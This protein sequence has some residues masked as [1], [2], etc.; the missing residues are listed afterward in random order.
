MTPG[1]GSATAAA[2]STRPAP[3][4]PLTATPDE[5]ARTGVV[6]GVGAYLL[7]GLLPLFLRLLHA[8]PALQIVAHRVLWSLVLLALVALARG[9]LSGVLAAARAPRALP[10]LCATAA[11]IAVNWSIYVWAAVNGHVVEASL[12]YFINPLVNVLLGVA[13]LGERLRRAQVAAVALAAVG[14]AAMAV[15]QGAALGISLG[16]ALSFG[17]YGLL[18]KLAPVEAFEGLAIESALLAPLALAFLL[19]AGAGGAGAWGRDGA[20]ELLLMLSGPVTAVPLLLFAAA[21]RRMRLATLGLLQYLSPTLQFL[22]GVL[23]FGEHLTRVH[24]FTFGCIWIG[25]I[26]YAADTLRAARATA[27]VPP[28]E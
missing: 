28:P 2:M 8:V 11:L 7:W 4:P 5:R 19:Y 25:L 1:G 26:V 3:L 18:R 27:V 12:G 9:R 16:L 14:V 22:Q 13:V 21:A 23:L 6:F 24:L 17:L 20:T 10:I 15:A